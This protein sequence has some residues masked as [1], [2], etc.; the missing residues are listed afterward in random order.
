MRDE[1]LVGQCKLQK[2][3]SVTL[4]RAFGGFKKVI[5]SEFNKTQRKKEK[6]EKEKEKLETENIFAR[7]F[8][9]HHALLYF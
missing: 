2:S 9:L 5:N 3:V 1:V 7:L 6:K 4:I 8:I